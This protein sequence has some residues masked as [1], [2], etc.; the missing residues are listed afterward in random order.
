MV[1]AHTDKSFRPEAYRSLDI[2]LRS[3]TQYGVFFRGSRS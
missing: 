2:G 1:C 3:K